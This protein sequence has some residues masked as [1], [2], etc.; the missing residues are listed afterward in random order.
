[1]RLTI[2]ALGALAAC[3]Q[4]SVT[5]P[6]SL[7]VGANASAS[8]PIVFNTQLRPENEIRTLP[9]DPVESAA[10][11]HAQIK[12]FADNTVAFKITVHNPGAEIFI[13]GHIHQAP[14]GVNGPIVVNLLGTI[15][16]SGELIKLEGTV[17]APPDI[18]AAIRSDP[19]G[20]YVNLHT[21]IDPQGAVRGQLP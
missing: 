18:A 19:A 1:M 12:L 10:R 15:S 2:F 17:A 6:L 5:E 4:A 9:D 7:A 8:A 3:T 16:Q 21:T 20:F 13:L 11:G 14:L